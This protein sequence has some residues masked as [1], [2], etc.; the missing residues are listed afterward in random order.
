MKCYWVKLNVSKW[1]YNRISEVIKI[2]FL[3]L[4]YMVWFCNRYLVFKVRINVIIVVNLIIK[5]D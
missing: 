3:K 2:W 4:F 1:F 5:E